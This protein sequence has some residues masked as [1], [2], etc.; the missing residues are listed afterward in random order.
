MG[1]CSALCDLNHASSETFILVSTCVPRYT[2]CIVQRS[3]SMSAILILIGTVTGNAEQVAAELATVFEYA[4]LT[5]T[6]LDM[7]DATPQLV[8]QHTNILICTSTHGSGDLPDNAEP[9]YNAL[10]EQKPELQHVYF[11]VCALGDHGYDPYFCEAGNLF[12][13]LFAYLG[14]TPVA[15]R[16]EIDGEPDEPTIEQAQAWAMDV[17]AA[18]QG[19][20]V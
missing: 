3:E 16:F 8:Q 6:L 15:E 1:M 2:A 5:P 7:Y 12:E 19:V 11:A 10:L 17:A 20:A 9:L 13:Q 14:A 18:L 4:G